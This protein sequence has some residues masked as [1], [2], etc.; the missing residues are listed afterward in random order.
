MPKCRDV[1]FLPEKERTKVRGKGTK[2]PKKGG[3]KPV[4]DLFAG[5]Y[6]E[7][8]RFEI[9]DIFTTLGF[10]VSI[11]LSV[12]RI[13]W[14]SNPGFPSALAVWSWKGSLAFKP[15]L[16]FSTCSMELEGKPG[17]RTQASLQHLQ[18]GAGREAWLS[19]PGFPSALAV[20]SWKGSLGSRLYRL[21]NES[22]I[23]DNLYC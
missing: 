9:V 12:A 2:K 7:R 3:E 23:S 1:F 19:N 13:A 5:N 15:R 17:F 21:Y 11:S 6:E 18:Y 4:L 20:W 10:A 22:I 16:P 14:L 8:R